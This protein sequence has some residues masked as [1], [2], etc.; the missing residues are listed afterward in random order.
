MYISRS[1]AEIKKYVGVVRLYSNSVDY[2]FGPLCIQIKL[3]RPPEITGA[4]RLR[5]V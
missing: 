3:R 1:F 4:L 5:V 2:F